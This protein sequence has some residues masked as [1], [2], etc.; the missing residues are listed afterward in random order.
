MNISIIIGKSIDLM[1]AFVK[2]INQHIPEGASEQGAL[3]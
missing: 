1:L 2:F 3:N